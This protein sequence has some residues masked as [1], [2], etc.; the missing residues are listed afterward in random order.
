[1]LTM[2]LRLMT[3]NQLQEKDYND[4]LITEKNSVE[5]LVIFSMFKCKVGVEQFM[6]KL[7]TPLTNILN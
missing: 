7:V 1:M 3:L 2:N 6:K 5:A 4:Q